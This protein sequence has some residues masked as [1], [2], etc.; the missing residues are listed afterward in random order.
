MTKIQKLFKKNGI[1]IQKLYRIMQNQKNTKFCK[2][3]Q[4]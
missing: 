4:N 3:V 2:I 1:I